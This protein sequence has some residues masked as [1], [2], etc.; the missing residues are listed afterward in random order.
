VIK[1]PEVVE[2]QTHRES[3][4]KRA[5]NKVLY[6]MGQT[7]KKTHFLVKAMSRHALGRGVRLISGGEYAQKNLKLVVKNRRL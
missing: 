2:K 6:R 3:V 7:S 4:Q 5:T 1:R